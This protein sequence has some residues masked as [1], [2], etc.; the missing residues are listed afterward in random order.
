MMLRVA[1]GLLVASLLSVGTVEVRADDRPNVLLI[2]AD[3]LA[4]ADLG[5]Y[6]HPWH[7]TPHLDRLASQGMRFTDGYAPAP[8]C[9]ASRAS[10][11]TGKST[12]R[13]GFEFVTKNAPGRQKRLPGQSLV[14]PPFTLNLPLEE[15]TVAEHLRDAGYHTAFFG[16]WHLNAHHGGYLGWS[17]TH[18]PKQQGFQTAIEGFGSHPYSFR[19]KRNK[20]PRITEPGRF[21]DDSMVG[22][23]IGFLTEDRREPFFLMVSHFYVHTPV[24]TRCEWLLDKYA[25]KAPADSPNRERRIAYGAFVETLDHYVGRLM[26]ALDESGRAGDTLVTFTSDNGGHPEYA[27]NGPLRGS[28]WNLYEGGCGLPT[29]MVLLV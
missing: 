8:I 19:G 10:I 9:S 24:E 20:P 6:G 2:L 22:G 28:K 4:W 15:T 17:P 11:L 5:C 12:A 3:D 14:T 18:G 27:A 26:T 25:G 23:A 29:T 16:K 13:L 1:T 21:P 7:E